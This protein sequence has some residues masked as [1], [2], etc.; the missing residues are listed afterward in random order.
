M[1][2][3]PQLE[4]DGDGQVITQ[5]LEANNLIFY[6]TIVVGGSGR[7]VVIGTGDSTVIGQIA[8]ER[9]GR[10]GVREGGRE[11]GRLVNG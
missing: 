7:G 2:R 9:G 1:E 4:S 10:E 3:G 6:T 8:G 5:P 11:A